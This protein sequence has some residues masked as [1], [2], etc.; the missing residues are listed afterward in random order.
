M[1]FQYLLFL[2]LFPLFLTICESI[3]VPL[4]ILL[5]CSKI[6]PFHV[7]YLHFKCFL[8][9][10]TF[11]IFPGK[12]DNSQVPGDSFLVY[13]KLFLFYR[14]H[15]QSQCSLSL[16]YFP[17]STK[18]CDNTQELQWTYLFP[19][20]HLPTGTIPMLN[21]VLFFHSLVPFF[22]YLLFDSMHFW[23]HPKPYH[24]ILPPLRIS[25]SQWV[26]GRF[27]SCLIWLV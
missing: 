25:L 17:L 2:S 1:Q 10:S 13:C 26:L 18:T 4:N 20:K 24:T 11:H 6:H 5:D 22:W 12:I 27:H 16:M 7:E 23:K 3:Q 15:L 14:Q 21:P 8:A 19:E 9:L